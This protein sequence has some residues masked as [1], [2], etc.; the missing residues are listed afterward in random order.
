MPVDFSRLSS[1]NTV[2]R[3][4]RFVAYRL[5]PG[6]MRLP[7][8]QGPARG[9]RW[10]AGA[11]VPACWLGCY[12]FEK[13]QRMVRHLRKGDTVFDIGAHRGYFTLVVSSLVG[14]EGKVIAFEPLPL[15]LQYLQ[16]HLSMNS[17]TNVTVI[18]MAVSDTRGTA[19]FD[20]APAYKNR[21]GGR[22]AENGSI[23]VQTVRLDDL[24]TEGRA[25]VPDHIKID[26]EGA[27]SRVLRGAEALLK[28][29]HPTLFID[30]HGRARHEECC[31]FLEQLEYQVECTGEEL[32]TLSDGTERYYGD[33][34]AIH[35]R[36]S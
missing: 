36:V 18:G 7:I 4:L 9:C 5:V 29:H 19:H 26:V 32:Y 13:Q 12:E 30:T 24:I 28:E 10:I 23:E 14:Q 35:P 22:L 1:R 21:V 27:E 25:P 15:N 17:I 16:K 8:L 11:H 33:L 34:L 3:M 2:G 6:Q 20:E 31:S